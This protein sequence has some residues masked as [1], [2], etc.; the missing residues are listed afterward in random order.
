MI[1]TSVTRT[2]GIRYPVMSA[3]MSLHSGGGL[4][5]AVTRAGGLGLFGAT[6]PAGPDWLREQIRIARDGCDGGPFGV[7]FITHLIPVFPELLDAALDEH[8]PVMAFS[9]ADPAPWTARAKD[10]GATVICQVQ[11]V[12][13]AEQAVAA[14]ADV[15][16]AQGNEAGGHTGHANLMPLLLRLVRDHPDLPVLAAGGIASPGALAA[17]LT[18]GAAGAWI[19]TALLA[20]PEAEHVSDAYKQRLIGAR[21]EDTRHTSVFDR[22]DEAAFGIPPWPD[23]IAGRAVVNALVEQWH[24]RE[25]ALAAQLDRVLP[26]YREALASRDPSR[27]AVWAGESVDFVT[28]IRP[29]ADVLRDI[30]EGAERRLRAGATAD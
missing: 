6:N 7:G 27:T 10:A 21:S 8:V 26:D 13:G 1:D 20:T 29:V 12:A 30:C 16:V 17:V 2:F 9:F 5:A 28:R 19:G 25:R 15:L 4:A 14:G 18:A 11:T 23:G 3:P 22:L 24:G